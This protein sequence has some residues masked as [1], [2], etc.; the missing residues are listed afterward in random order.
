MASPDHTL[1]VQGGASPEQSCFFRVSVSRV[2][3]LF[4]NPM[5][6]R[7]VFYGQT[8]IRQGYGTVGIRGWIKKTSYVA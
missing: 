7:S 6:I 5:G 3:G 1:D 4:V 2:S 8:L